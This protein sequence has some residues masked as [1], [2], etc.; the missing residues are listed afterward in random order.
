LSNKLLLVEDEEHLAFSLRFNLEAEGFAVD[1]AASL[2]AAHGWLA[3][4]SYDA[5]VLDV[6]LPDGDGIDFCRQLRSAGDR[7]PILILT[8]LGTT[9]DVVRGLEAGADDYVTKPFAWPELL[10]R[11]MAL[12]RRQRWDRLL[13][14]APPRGQVRFG[15]GHLVDLDR[16]HAYTNGQQVQ[17]TDLEFALLAFFLTHPNQAIPRERLLEEVWRL[18]GTLQTRT[19]D[20]FLV[21]LRRQFERDPAHPEHF[22]TVRGAGYRFRP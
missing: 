22:Q 3:S 7:S 5:F 8:A 15:A 10:G 20:N 2:A 21:R 12:L 14:S 9:A 16:G 18:P 6:M 17:L 1:H 11:L 4:T 13:A 19:V